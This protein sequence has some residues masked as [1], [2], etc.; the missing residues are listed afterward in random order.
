MHAAG[1]YHEQSRED[2]DQYV[3]INE[4]NIK[5]G[6][7][8]NFQIEGMPRSDYDYSSIMH[9]SQKAFS[10]NELPTIECIKNGVVVACAP[11]MGQR[12]ELS[13]GDIHGISWFYSN[14]SNFPCEAFIPN[15]FPE[16]FPSAVP[17]ASESAMAAFRHRT[18]VAYKERHVSE[19][20]KIVGA[21]PNFHEVTKGI[22][23]VGGTV[24]LYNISAQWQDVPLAELGSPPL[25]DFMGRMRATQVYAVQNGFIGGYPTFYHADYGK[26]VVCG[27]VL[28]RPGGAEWRDVP[29]TELGNPS[30]DDIRARMT[31]ANDYAFRNG[32]LGGFPTF[33]HADYGKG[34]VCG[35]VLIKKEAGEWRDVIT[36]QGPR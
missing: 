13:A 27:T 33:F 6:L 32:F 16:K 8:N 31:S 14:T 29:L 20:I 24:F 34:I 9:Y 21:Y 30:L 1:F 11:G 28:I 25:N 7:E 17:V 22:N 2:R 15:P 23:T 35:I 3:K 10:K 4:A 36:V 26:G 5:K 18:D 12:E 19:F